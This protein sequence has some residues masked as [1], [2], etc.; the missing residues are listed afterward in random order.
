M[1]EGG[2]RPGEGSVTDRT[3]L[4]GGLRLLATEGLET[5]LLRTWYAGRKPVGR[6][7]SR[8]ADQTVPQSRGP[9]L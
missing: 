4:L 2:R 5:G 7:Q 9:V 1:G 6:G 8:R 3:A